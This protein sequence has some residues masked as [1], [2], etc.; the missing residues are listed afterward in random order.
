MVLRSGKIIET[1]THETLLQQ[2]GFYFR[3]NQLQG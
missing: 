1:G 3:L 2:K